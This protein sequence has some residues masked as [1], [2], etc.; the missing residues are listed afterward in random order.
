MSEPSP[1]EGF[2][3]TGG[4]V[5]GSS[6]RIRPGTVF[7]EGLPDLSNGS[8]APTD[9]M[10]AAGHEPYLIVYQSVGDPSSSGTL[11]VPGVISAIGASPLV[12]TTKYGVLDFENPYIQ[13][14]RD[15][16]TNQQYAAIVQELVDC[17]SAVKSAYPGIK[18][19]Y[20]GFPH[21]PFFFNSNTWWG[22]EEQGN[23]AAIDAEIDEILN[24]W[25]TVLDSQDF[26]SPSMYDR[27][28]DEDAGVVT[29]PLVPY[30]R[31]DQQIRFSHYGVEICKRHI[32]STGVGKPIIPFVC[33]Q[34]QKPNARPSF[35]TPENIPLNELAEQQIIPAV[36]NGAQDI[37]W[38]T[39]L[40]YW[41]SQVNNTA[42]FPVIAPEQPDA[43]GV[44]TTDPTFANTATA[45]GTTE[46]RLRRINEYRAAFV[47]DYLDGVDPADWATQDIDVIVTGIGEAMLASANKCREAM[48]LAGA[49]RKSTI[50]AL[51]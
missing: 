5:A 3:G 38:W 36:L 7:F 37:V 50:T 23:T 12:G 31:R 24:H 17:M 51:A 19:S 40:S 33:P 9:N 27:Y 42:D 41:S 18:W 13:V 1:S 39:G 21:V 4:S 20:Y 46:A 48:R 43:A 6:G 11:N 26:Y 10:I 22:F 15:G 47:H 44:I 28:R 16:P 25:G 14:I 35:P 29:D 30:A 45:V 2:E 32:A 34:F 8:T 49:A